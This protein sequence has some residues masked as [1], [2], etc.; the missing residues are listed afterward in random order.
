MTE[1]EIQF[2]DEFVFLTFNSPETERGKLAEKAA[3]KACYE[4]PDD[5][6]ERDNQLKTLLEKPAIRAYIKVETN[7]I[8]QKFSGQ[9][10]R[11]LWAAILDMNI[12]EPAHDLPDA[13]PLNV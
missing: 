12:G 3:L 13:L 11:N 6:V 10:R 2:A 7:E 5:V 1:R 9:Q 4:L 8:K